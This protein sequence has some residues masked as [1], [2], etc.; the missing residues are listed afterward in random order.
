MKGIIISTLI[1][2]L[3]FPLAF[4]QDEQPVEILNNTITDEGVRAAVQ[5]QQADAIVEGKMR[6]AVEA[7]ESTEEEGVAIDED[8]EKVA[9]EPKQAVKVGDVT[10]W[11]GQAL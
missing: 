1:V 3:F 6:E 10:S 9:Q 7:G 5:A 8:I 4:G 11:I 2:F